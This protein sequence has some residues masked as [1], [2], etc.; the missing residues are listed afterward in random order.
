MKRGGPAE[1]FRL[2]PRAALDKGCGPSLADLGL[3]VSIHVVPAGEGQA[4]VPTVFAFARASL[5]PLL[6]AASS[7]ALL[8]GCAGTRGGPIPYSPTGFVAPD[9]GQ[10]KVLEDDY[11]ISPLD[12]LKISVFQVP[13]LS[14]DFQVDL[15]GNVSL[16]LLGNVKAVN[17]TTAELDDRL[18]QMLGAK[19]LQHPDVSVGVKSSSTRNV[20]VDGSV[21]NGGVFPITGP[22]TLLQAIALAHGPDENA[23]PHRVAVFR[24]IKGERMAAAFDLTAIRRGQ[25]EDPRV[26]AGDIIVV[27][28]SKVKSTWQNVLQAIPLFAI[29]RPFG[30]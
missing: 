27:D 18:T 26:F 1:P 24:T 30:L 10:P 29:F 22:L 7:A 3:S 23:N 4:P 15:T 25:A 17:L 13:D 12:T 19:Y 28:G 9:P 8:A 6:V 14:G 16:P 21:K 5:R 11:R 2:D 20:T